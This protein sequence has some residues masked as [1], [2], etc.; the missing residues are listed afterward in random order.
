MKETTS[1]GKPLN[2]TGVREKLKGKNKQKPGRKRPHS[3]DQDYID[4]DTSPAQRI[5]LKDISGDLEQDFRYSESLDP[6]G[7]CLPI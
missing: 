6:P 5:S 4:T 3:G 2:L 7:V 1:Q